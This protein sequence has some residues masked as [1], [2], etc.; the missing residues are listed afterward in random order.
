M[1]RFSEDVRKKE[2]DLSKNKNINEKNKLTYRSNGH[3]LE[4]TNTAQHFLPCTTL[5]CVPA[6]RIGNYYQ[7]LS[8][9][10]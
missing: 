10:I 7:S 2:L 8:M 1:S 6:Q 4:M 9:V 3:F 5:K